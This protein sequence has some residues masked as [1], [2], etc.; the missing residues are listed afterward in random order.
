MYISHIHILVDLDLMD[1]L[2]IL[3][4]DH[5]T[6]TKWFNFA[7]IARTLMIREA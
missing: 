5:S 2:Y 7:L 4:V 1:P 3:Q 6:V